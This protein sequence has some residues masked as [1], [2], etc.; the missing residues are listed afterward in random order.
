MWWATT[1]KPNIWM[2]QSIHKGDM[3]RDISGKSLVEVTSV[4]HYS[5][6]NP[7]QFDV[8]LSLKLKV[9][10]LK[11]NGSYIFNR[12]PLIVGA[13]IELNLPTL[14]STGTVIQISDSPFK[15]IVYEKEISLIKRS[16]LNDEYSSIKVGD[17]YNNGEN[18]VFEILSKNNYDTFYLGRDSNGDTSPYAMEQRK[19]IVLKAKIQVK[20]S[21]EEYIFGEEQIIKKGKPFILSTNTL[22]FNDYYVFDIQ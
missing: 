8:Y 5:T 4:T 13:P 18:T 14:S 3:Q 15:E 16:A 20:K 22:A 9:S 17:S 11:S 19:S 10:R 2:V 12:S 1:A 7:D 21:G 6:N